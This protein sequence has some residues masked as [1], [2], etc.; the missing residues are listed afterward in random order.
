MSLIEWAVS[1]SSWFAK[2]SK[3]LYTRALI[4]TF[5]KLFIFFVLDLVVDRNRIE[6]RKSNKN[7]ILRWIVVEWLENS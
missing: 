3:T 4:Q 2:S 1:A 5:Q 7:V 6:N